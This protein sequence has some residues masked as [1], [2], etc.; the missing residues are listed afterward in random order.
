MQT[1]VTPEIELYKNYQ[2][3]INFLG[4]LFKEL[5]HFTCPLLWNIKQH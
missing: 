2:S 1:E 5:T 3:S 4:H